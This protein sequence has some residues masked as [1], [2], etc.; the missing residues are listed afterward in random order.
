[1]M[2]VPDLCDISPGCQGELPL[3]NGA[4]S[5]QGGRQRHPLNKAPVSQRLSPARPTAT[6]AAGCAKPLSLGQ[7]EPED[8]SITGSKGSGEPEWQETRMLAESLI[9]LSNKSL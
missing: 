2:S 5:S 8:I 1:M 3:G 6:A 7:A 4:L 9:Q